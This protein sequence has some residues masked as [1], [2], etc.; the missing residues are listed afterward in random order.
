MDKQYKRYK[1]YASSVGAQLW[2]GVDWHAE[3]D[4]AML[5]P[6]AS[7]GASAVV[8]A[9]SLG[10]SDESVSESAAPNPSS[11]VMSFKI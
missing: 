9:G 8:Y 7:P 6:S 5:T 10:A 4:V 2:M 11:I 1:P 3:L